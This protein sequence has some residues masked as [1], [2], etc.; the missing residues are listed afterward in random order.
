[1]LELNN[2][3]ERFSSP[4]LY[5]YNPV[6]LI[7]IPYY[8]I[9]NVTDE[10][11]VALI[12]KVRDNSYDINYDNNITCEDIYNYVT[13]IYYLNNISK[14]VLM[15]MLRNKYR[16]VDTKNSKYKYTDNFDIMNLDIDKIFYY[17]KKFTK[18]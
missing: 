10:K 2:K 11:G 3:R 13:N 12:S 4:L 6:N 5:L 16:V 1:M 7:K 9:V 18:K 15:S 8:H 17:Y 14:L